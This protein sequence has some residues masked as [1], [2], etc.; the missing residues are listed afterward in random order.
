MD[1]ERKANILL[2]EDNPD[3]EAMIMRAVRKSGFPCQILVAHTTSEALDYL[4]RS[5]V[6]PGGSTVKPDVIVTDFR[7]HPEGGAALVSAVRNDP[8]TSLIPIVVFSG[9]ASEKD[10]VDLYLRGANSFLE[11]PLDF[12]SFCGTIERMASYWGGLNLTPKSFPAATS[13]T[14]LL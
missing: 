10:I 11:K 8:R 7:I 2:V 13:Y 14:A 5:E 3:E 12:D 4:H 6:T 9:S 1:S